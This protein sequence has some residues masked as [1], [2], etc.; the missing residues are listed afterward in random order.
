MSEQY[1]CKAERGTMATKG[2]SWKY[3]SMLICQ[4]TC[5]ALDGHDSNMIKLG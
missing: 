1:L 5:P 4:T 2:N 3:A